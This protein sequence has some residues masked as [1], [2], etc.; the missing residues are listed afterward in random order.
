MHPHDHYLTVGNTHSLRVEDPISEF[1]C[2][3]PIGLHSLYT[4][5]D[6]IGYFLKF[7]IT[8][9]DYTPEKCIVVIPIHSGGRYNELKM[10]TPQ[11]II[12]N[13][14]E[15]TLSLHPTPLSENLQNIK[16]MTI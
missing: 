11:F 5:S 4:H 10:L 8:Q 16:W 14:D 13:V 3:H 9:G 6:G 12:T 2:T 1:R 7:L 15:K